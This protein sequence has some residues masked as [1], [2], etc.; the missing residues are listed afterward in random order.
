MYWP[1]KEDVQAISLIPNPHSR[2][3]GITVAHSGDA[4]WGKLNE[5]RQL[6]H[7]NS[8]W[9]VGKFL[10]NIISFVDDGILS[11]WS[12]GFNRCWLIK[13]TSRILTHIEKQITSYETL[14]WSRYKKL[15]AVRDKIYSAFHAKYT[16]NGRN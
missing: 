4:K 15:S 12:H 11:E 9:C 10:K 5:N 16:R 7:R 13:S 14:A 1:D 8:C 6:K 2:C 3:K